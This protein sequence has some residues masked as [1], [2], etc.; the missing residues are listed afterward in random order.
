MQVLMNFIK[1]I[2]MAII[3][4]IAENLIKKSIAAWKK[5]K[6]LK[7]KITENKKKTEAYEKDPSDDN[8]S[9]LP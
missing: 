7:K 8:F 9:K 1:W 3:Y 5:S 2:F 6:E 4:P